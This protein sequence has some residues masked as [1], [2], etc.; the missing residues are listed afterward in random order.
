MTRIQTKTVNQLAG[1]VQEGPVSIFIG[2]VVWS[3]AVIGALWFIA[4]YL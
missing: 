4:T 2:Q 1:R 3:A